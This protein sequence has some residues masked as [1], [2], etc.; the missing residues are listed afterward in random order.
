RGAPDHRRPVRQR[1]RRAQNVK[2]K[3]V[4]PMGGAGRREWSRALPQYVLRFTFYAI[5]VR[6]W[7]TV[8]GSARKVSK[9]GNAF[10]DRRP[11]RGVGDADVGSAG[12]EDR[13]GDGQDVAANRLLDE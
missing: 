12:R 7:R 3:G 4:L 10:F 9:D 5:P 1:G 2:R 11:G 6:Q 13:A 8:L